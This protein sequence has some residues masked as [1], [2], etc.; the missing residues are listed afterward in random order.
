MSLFKGTAGPWVEH[1]DNGQLAVVANNRMLA[2]VPPLHPDARANLKAIVAIP[3]M[4]EAL[5]DCISFIESQYFAGAIITAPAY[6]KAK[7]ALSKAID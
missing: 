6:L 1:I 2:H 4:Q 7:A 3:D 5:Q